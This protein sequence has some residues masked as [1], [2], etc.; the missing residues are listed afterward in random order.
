MF[1]Y[2]RRKKIDA[3]ISEW[4]YNLRDPVEVKPGK[5][6]FNYRCFDN[7]VQYAKENKSTDVVMGITSGGGT[8]S[9]HF[10]NIKNGKHID[11]TLGYK[12]EYISY[13]QLRIIDPKDY[14]QIDVV[15]GDALDFFT[16]KFT[17][18]WDRFLLNG[19]RIL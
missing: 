4:L 2:D 18:K 14:D 9:L 12:S 7:S 10:W 1:G 8:T 17:T 16:E 19:H 11:N 5:G 13:Y 6:S 15:F 3:Y